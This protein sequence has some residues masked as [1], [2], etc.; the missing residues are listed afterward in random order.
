M[1][2][3]ELIKSAKDA[4]KGL[5]D[6]GDPFTGDD[7]SLFQV[8]KHYVGL[9]KEVVGLRADSELYQRGYKMIGAC[10]ISHYLALCET[11]GEVG[12]EKM[13]DLWNKINLSS[14]IKKVKK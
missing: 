9:S 7:W 13:C 14:G 10:D 4:M 6:H 8:L 5:V 11:A 2:D 12:E 3:E 1:T